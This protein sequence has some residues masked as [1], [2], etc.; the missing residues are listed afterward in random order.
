MQ[1]QTFTTIGI[2]RSQ[3]LLG[4]L[5]H[6]AN[7][8]SGCGPHLT[9]KIIIDL[10]YIFF[11][12]FLGQDPLDL[13]QRQALL[14]HADHD[15]AGHMLPTVALPLRSR[16]QLQAHIVIYCA[17]CDHRVCLILGDQIQI[18]I[19]QRDHLVHVQF[20]VRQC[21]PGREAEMLHILPPPVQLLHKLFPIVGQFSHLQTI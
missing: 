18:T 14:Q 19:H 10:V 16:H 7:K 20:H 15:H 8:Q 5:I 21:L 13:R 4:N 1:H 3:H 2:L 17:G 6:L 12:H 11:R 9:G